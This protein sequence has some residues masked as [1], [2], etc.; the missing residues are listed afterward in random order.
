MRLCDICMDPDPL[1]RKLAVGRISF[2][3]TVSDSKLPKFRAYD[4]CEECLTN[5]VT[6]IIEKKDG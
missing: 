6:L 5:P 1:K 3:R 2:E 4:I